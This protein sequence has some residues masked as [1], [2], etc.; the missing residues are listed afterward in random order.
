MKKTSFLLAMCLVFLTN[1]IANP[2]DKQTAQRAA[3][4]FWQKT[5][6]NGIATSASDWT[7]LST[8]YNTLYVFE[9]NLGQGFVV[10]AADD[11]VIP[12][13]GYSDANGWGRGELPVNVNNWL[14][15]CD[16]QVRY[17]I[18]N[19]LE[20]TPEIDG[21]WG[22]L[23]DGSYETPQGAA[24]S[25]LLST[26]WNQDRYYN[27][28]CPTASN[29]PGGRCYAGCVATATGQ[30]MKYWNY[31]KRGTGS[32]SFNHATYGT[33][34]ANFGNTVYNWNNMPA[35]LSSSS[36]SAQK[37]A[38]A[39]LLYHI[40]VS[41]DMNYSP[42]GSGASSYL[43]PIGQANAA[44]S[45]VRYFGYK[46]SIRYNAKRVYNTDAQWVA[47]LTPELDAGRPMLYCGYDNSQGFGH[48]FVCDG[49][50]NQSRMHFDW[51][52]SGSYN[53]Y[54][55][56]ASLNPG[57]YNLSQ[58]QD[59][60][61]RIEPDT[62]VLHVSEECIN[63]ASSAS[64][65]TLYVMAGS[66][67]S[68]WSASCNQSWVTLSATSGNGSS[69]ISP[70]TLNFAANTTGAARNATL[71]VTQNGTTRTV[72]LHQESNF[73]NDT[74]GYDDNNWSSSMGMQ[75]GCYW[76]IRIPS[77][78]LA[79]VRSLSDVMIYIGYAGT[80]QL[81]VYSG[82]ATGTTTQLGNT[83][84]RTF[85][86]EGGWQTYHLDNPI[87]VDPTKSLWIV[88]YNSNVDYP[89][90]FTAT[91][92]ISGRNWFSSSGTSWTNY[93]NQNNAGTRAFMIRAIL[94]MGSCS[95]PT[96]VNLSGINGS[97]VN[98]SW[99]GSAS[100]YLVEYGAKGF[101]RGRGTRSV[102]STTSCTLNNLTS[103]REYDVYVR[104]ICG[105]GDSS[106]W[107]SVCTFALGCRTQTNILSGE[108]PASGWGA[109]RSSGGIYD[110]AERF[111]NNQ[112]IYIDSA[113]IF[114]YKASSS[115]P[116]TSKIK[117]SIY[118]EVDNA[119]GTAISTQNVPYS[120][121]T[122]GKW[123]NI[124]FQSPVPVSGN[125][126][127]V[128]TIN[129]TPTT[130]TFYFVSTAS[131]SNSNNTAYAKYNGSWS[132][133]PNLFQNSP[134]VS[135][136]FTAKVCPRTGATI[137][138]IN[139]APNNPNWGSVSGTGRYEAGTT[140]TLTATPKRGYSF[141]KW[142]DNT[143]TNPRT[144]TVS[145][146]ATYNAQ[147]EQAAGIE[148]VEDNTLSIFPNP[149]NGIVTVGSDDVQQIDVVDLKGSL[150][151]TTRNSNSVDLTDLPN[152]TYFLRI[153]QSEGVVIRKVVKK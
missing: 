136:F 58:N 76:A 96:N 67:S 153:T 123:N 104:S 142:S 148:E 110:Y 30:I 49:Y 127:I 22:A 145:G 35:G 34:T 112:S 40:G 146:N 55:S 70:I 10:I 77:E 12:I 60:V 129:Q 62:T 119:P 43:T 132:R 46:T 83:I 128:L 91:G 85:N 80:Y 90:C 109:I 89:A 41:V 20:S 86:Y 1:V 81:K 19:N 15:G 84:T 21:M 26:A 130:D 78:D 138:S 59:I 14:K 92:G 44:N 114:V 68:T 152:G 57:S 63:A 6:N 103:G 27:G 31:P 105:A 98:I 101:T 64:T 74:I 122:S 8:P 42:D 48:A 137:Y 99:R 125:Y 7:L 140:V 151:T 121:L 108:Q 87:T 134:C 73:N 100:N 120:K 149:T 126:Y 72:Y 113:A 18:D 53:G 147:F 79:G 69:T 52:W 39:T 65:Q 116:T 17:V 29:G 4:T 118:N 47:V 102:V 5:C 3:Q 88:F 38:I 9:Y 75:N 97:S 24:V 93:N 124:A 36:S 111:E 94:N 141:V 54:Y 150:M 66:N 56:V 131:R 28:L 61:Y 13:I 117:V 45:L 37:T 95:A 25:P 139:G 143:T 32:Y 133:F 16:E 115:S 2:V 106:A 107:S 11:H 71:T 144:I 33:Q 50:D 23:L 51:G 82:T 135:L